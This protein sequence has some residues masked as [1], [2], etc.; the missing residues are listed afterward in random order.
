MSRLIFYIDAFRLLTVF[1]SGYSLEIFALFML[2]G[3]ASSLLVPETMNKTLEEL[4][5]EEEVEDDFAHGKVAEAG[6]SAGNSDIHRRNAHP[7]DEKVLA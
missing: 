7:D 4:N 2:T 3:I 5:G 1:P 6:S